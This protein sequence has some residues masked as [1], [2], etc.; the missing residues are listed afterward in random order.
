MLNAGGEWAREFSFDSQ[1]LAQM[2]LF[3]WLFFMIGLAAHAK[4]VWDLH[5]QE[6]FHPVTNLMCDL[7][8]I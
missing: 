8:L 2:Y 1:G 5:Q 7:F 3:F 6:S 4:G